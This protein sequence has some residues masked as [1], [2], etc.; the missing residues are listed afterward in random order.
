MKKGNDLHTA[1]SKGSQASNSWL[2]LLHWLWLLVL[3]LTRIKNF[4]LNKAYKPIKSFQK[5][6]LLKAPTKTQTAKATKLTNMNPTH[7]YIKWGVMLLFAFLAKFAAAQTGPYQFTGNDDVCIGQTKNYG[8]TKVPG[9]TYSWTITPG[10]EGVDWNLTITD[11]TITVK[12]LKAGTYTVSVAETNADNCTGDAVQIT[13]TVHDLPVC[14]I[15]GPDNICPGS[16]NVYSG[17]NPAPP[18]TYTYNW[19]IIGDATISGAS[20]A[21]NVS[22]VANNICGSYTLTLVLTNEFGCASTCT[23]TYNITAPPVV[24]N[25]PKDTLVSSCLTQAQVDA[26]FADWLAR[27]TSS[28]GCT[29]VV[30]NDATAAPPACGGSVTVTWTAKSPCEADVIKSAT[31]TVTKPE[32]VVVAP[33]SALTVKSC[34]YTD[35]A[36]LNAAFQTWLG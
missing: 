23:Q 25:P 3:S 21:Q 7:R 4:L 35:Q 28:G 8:V 2:P 31:F 13:V 27:V 33:P 24:L 5:N 9:S 22:V 30:T 20:N 34:D 6:V 14:S 11:N 32:P 17:P 16:T 19:S 10:T 26:A 12:W 18:G 29:L 1:M 36:A 15:T